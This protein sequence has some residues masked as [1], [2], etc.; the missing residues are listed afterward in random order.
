MDYFSENTSGGKYSGV[1]EILPTPVNSKVFVFLTQLSPKSTN[2][3]YPCLSI[4]TFSGFKLLY[5]Q[6]YSL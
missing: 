5:N 2:L 4:K 3:T 6:N 1:P